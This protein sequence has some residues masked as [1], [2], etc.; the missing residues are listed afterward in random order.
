MGGGN[1]K[2]TNLKP[3]ELQ[4]FQYMTSLPNDILIDLHRLFNNFCN[5]IKDDG[6]IDYQEFLI[7]IDK[8][9]CTLTKH[10]FRA[11]DTNKDNCINF[12]EF[13]KFICCF[14]TGN[15][16]EQSVY[17]FKIFANDETK[18]I[19]KSSMAEFLRSSLQL[20][21]TLCEYLDEKAI[22]EIVK[23]SFEKMNIIGEEDSLNLEQ[24][25]K[26]LEKYPNILNWF[27]LD[28]NKI[29]NNLR[30]KTR[31]TTCFG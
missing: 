21:K 22:D 2:R 8:N 19:E 15:F 4:D 11:I 10:L 31:S 7:M 23:I 12:R 27:K 25:K 30:E 26:F 24:Y 13:L 9:D 20:D 3:F 14:I 6:V 1:V 17:S 29:K 28:L 16:E 5:S 18:L